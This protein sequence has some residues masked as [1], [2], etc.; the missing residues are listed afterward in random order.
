MREFWNKIEYFE[1]REFK[2]PDSEE[3][4]I[5]KTLVMALDA[6]RNK[7]ERPMR[8]NSGYRTPEHNEKVGGVKNSQH[9]KGFAADVHIDNQIIGDEIEAL[10]IE[11]VG[12]DCGV[13][14]Y[15]TFIHLDVRG[16]KARWDKRTR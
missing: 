9:L 3:D 5:D 2:S 4:K 1:P 10:F 8:I 15:N 16:T 14:R 13:G 11:A 7:L 12:E 6:V